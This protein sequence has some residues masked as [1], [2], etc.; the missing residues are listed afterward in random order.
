MRGYPT[1]SAPD[2]Y[3]HEDPQEGSQSSRSSLHTEASRAA[4]DAENLVRDLPALVSPK[5]AA[6][7]LGLTTRTLRNYRI[8]GR[9]RAIKT[10][11]G[12]SGRV[13]YARAEI[14]RLLGTM[15]P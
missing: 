14:A 7:F 9:I 13:R 4:I 3:P 8:A 1:N 11:P 5:Q 6:E 12:R 10:S 15:M 2:G